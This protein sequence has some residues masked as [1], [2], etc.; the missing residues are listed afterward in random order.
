MNQKGL[1]P[2][3]IVI[4]IAAA[5]GGY[6]IYKNQNKVAPVVQKTPQP[7]PTSSDETTNWKTYNEANSGFVIKYPNS[8]NQFNL[9]DNTGGYVTKIVLTPQTEN[10]LNKN[11]N[12][13][14]IGVLNLNIKD[15]TD[16]AD[17]SNTE[18]NEYLRLKD[19]LYPDLEIEQ[20]NLQGI[21]GYV[22]YKGSPG[23]VAQRGP[24]AYIFQCPKEIQISF[25][26]TGIENSTQLFDQILST[27]KFTQ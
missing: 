22:I 11:T 8:W 21:N 9:P 4:L 23:A 13:I 18:F 6:F 12:G 7:L 10:L 1:A 24:E 5:I 16:S 2:I 15:C 19:D 26:P 20:L 3:L 27:L 17:Y 14:T 25:D